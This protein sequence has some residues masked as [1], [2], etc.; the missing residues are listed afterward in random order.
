MCPKCRRDAP[1]VY[2]GVMAYCAACGAPRLPLSG[3]SVAHAGKSSKLGGTVARVAGWTV[4][5]AGLSLALLLGAVAHAL[6]PAGFVGL[7]LGVPIAAIALV[8]GLVLLR[9][10]KS[11]RGT[12]ESL[13]RATR[14]QAVHA[15]AA[16]R[17]GSLTSLDVAQA[18]SIPF[19]EADALLTSMAKEQMD[20]VSVEID[21]SGGLYYRFAGSIDGDGAGTDAGASRVRVDP[22]IALSPNRAEW[23]R[24]EAEETAGGSAAPPNARA[25]RPPR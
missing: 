21:P 23:E 16:N 18:L 19:E 1:L 3:A 25:A 7:A 14:A 15:L 5:G 13:E 2:R 6:F 12:G 17:G 20:H 9:S 10:G 8:I 11:L 24:L 22:E 4:L